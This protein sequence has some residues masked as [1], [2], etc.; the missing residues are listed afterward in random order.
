MTLFINMR[1]AAIAGGIPAEAYVIEART[2]SSMKTLPWAEVH[3]AVSG[4]RLLIHCHGFNVPMKNAIDSGVVIE[5]H[6]KLAADEQFMAVLWPGDWHVPAVNYAFEHWDA[7]K[8]GRLLARF[9]DQHCGQAQ[10]LSLGSH[11]LGGRVVLEALLAMSAPVRQMCIAAPAVDNDCLSNRFA[12]ALSRVERLTV[13]S[14]KSDRVLR[15]AYPLGDFFS[16]VFGDDD[17]AF[18][19]AM[20]L[21]GPRPMPGP[22]VRAQAI[23]T[24]DKYDHGDYFPGAAVQPGGKAPKW[25]KATNFWAKALRA[26]GV[27]TW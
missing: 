23:P 18:R 16:D 10:S 5:G 4:K 22:P 3:K 6:I 14:S 15:W 26:E 9:L 19:G 7:M 11:S 1:Q 13:L 24:D 20:G 12:E 25:V 2:A 21:K 27:L 8:S 17:S